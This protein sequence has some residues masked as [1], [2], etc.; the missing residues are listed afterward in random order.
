MG[1]F[2]DWLRARAVAA[3]P[4]DEA[5]WRETVAD[6]PIMDAMEPEDLSRLRFLATAFLL[7]KEFF[8]PA[9]C[10]FRDSDRLRIAIFAC[11]P[12]LG[13][14]LDW[15]SDWKSIYVLPDLFRSG[16]NGRDAQGY[17][18]ED[19]EELSGQVFELGPVAFSLKDI[20]AG[21]RGTGYN[22]VI[23]EMCHKLDGRDGAIQG[24][25]VLHQ[26]MS[27]TAWR[28]AFTDAWEA[29]RRGEAAG[30]RRKQR[31]MLRDMDPYGAQDPA[32]FFA[33][34]C[35]YFFERPVFLRG[36]HP[37]VYEQLVAFFRRDPAGRTEKLSR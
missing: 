2:R 25:P 37:G 21:G 6:L 36:R 15:Y 20:R 5:L 13:L 19:D 17:V 31:G 9:D 27:A 22:V 35:E 30:G 16:S 8:A 18:E 32:E 26:G 24:C 4:L 10:D 29:L 14:S 23:H 11:L 3:R 34:A 33:V 1:R 7:E 28:E 12:L